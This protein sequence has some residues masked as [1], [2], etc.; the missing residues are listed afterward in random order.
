[1]KKLTVN[2]QTEEKLRKG[3]LVLDKNDF[4]TLLFTDQCVELHSQQGKFLGTAYLS[5]QR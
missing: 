1:M 3:I 2:K 5:L 4:P